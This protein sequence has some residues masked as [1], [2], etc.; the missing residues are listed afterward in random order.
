MA[1]GT[2][3]TMKLSAN[4]AQGSSAA[5]QTTLDGMR[6]LTEVNLEAACASRKQSAAQIHALLLSKDINA[7]AQLV[8]AMAQPSPETFTAYAQAVTTIAR[9]ASSDM[10]RVVR[11][12]VQR[13]NQPIAATVE[14]TAR[15]A[16]ASS[17]S[18][19]QFNQNVQRAPAMDTQGK[20]Q[21]QSAAAQGG[22]NRRR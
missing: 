15:T 7:L 6:R 17:A 2:D 19:E 9:D 8:T 10:A 21:G 13:T 18:D 4:M 14:A 12:Q 16:P 1:Q 11:V 22:R 20:Q 5:M 3:K